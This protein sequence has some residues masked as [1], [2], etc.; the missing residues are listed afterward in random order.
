MPLY[1]YRCLPCL[2]YSE[3]FRSL[4]NRNDR[5][6]CLSCGREMVRKI[7]GAVQ[8][9]PPTGAA[10]RNQFRDFTDAASE[11]PDGVASSLWTQAK[12]NAAG[13]IAAGENTLTPQ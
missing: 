12:S 13:I 11:L 6:A 7:T 1:E 2:R 8:L 9:A 10:V 5:P 3:Q 4:D